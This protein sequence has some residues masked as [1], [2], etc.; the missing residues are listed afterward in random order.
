MI[1]ELKLHDKDFLKNWIESNAD[2]SIKFINLE[3][4]IFAFCLLEKLIQTKVNFIF[5]GGTALILLLEDTKRFSTDID[6]LIS[7][8]SMEI[9]EELFDSFVNK[10]EIFTRWEEDIRPESKFPKAHYKFYFDAIYKNGIEEGYILLDAV[11]EKNPYMSLESKLI[12]NYILPTKEPHEKVILPSITDIMIDK[13]TA[14]APNTIGVK[15]ERQSESG[16][17]TDHSREVVKQWFDVSELFQKCDNFQELNSR[18]IKLSSFEIEQRDLSDDYL[19]CLADT[20][21]IV[22]NYLS[23]GQRDV[24]TNEKIKKGIRR[25]NSFVNIDLTDSY[26]IS[27]SVNVI[28]LISKVLCDNSVRYNEIFEKSKIEFPYE[29]FLKNRNIKSIVEL[30]RVNNRSDRDRFVSALRVI[31]NFIEF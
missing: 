14:F 27:A 1:D 25:L 8:P 15:F 13:L 30:V 3:R 11:F 28:T 6:I 10:D 5:K 7:K 21:N 2:N 16:L 26:F 19:S 20:L 31:S 29:E 17:T 4:Q 23:R 18:Y 22:L 9:L 12:Q 24:S